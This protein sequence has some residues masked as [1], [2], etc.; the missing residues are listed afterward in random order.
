MTVE[1]RKA[2]QTV[3]IDEMQ[4]RIQEKPTMLIDALL[5]GNGFTLMHFIL[6]QR[7]GQTQN[8]TRMLT[9]LLQALTEARPS[10]EAAA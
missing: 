10:D 9:Q 5:A 1:E 6:T 4:A 7:L 2:L 8:A 3:L